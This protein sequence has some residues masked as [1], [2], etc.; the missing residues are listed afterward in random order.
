MTDRATLSLKKS[1]ASLN[2][3]TVA[4]DEVSEATKKATKTTKEFQKTVKVRGKPTSLRGK[5]EQKPTEYKSRNKHVKLE[6][7]DAQPQASVADMIAQQ[8]FNL[9]GEA[10]PSK[11]TASP[12]GPKTRKMSKSDKCWRTLRSVRDMQRETARILKT[13]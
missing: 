11:Y 6:V 1:A 4:L 2:K 8:D 10:R 7:V 13:A 3:A 5:A 9:T 12:Y